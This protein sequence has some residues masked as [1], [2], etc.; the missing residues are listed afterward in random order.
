MN[1]NISIY[2]KL[3]YKDPKVKNKTN[4]ESPSKK[5]NNDKNELY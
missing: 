2:E 3:M 5:N 1:L 4:K